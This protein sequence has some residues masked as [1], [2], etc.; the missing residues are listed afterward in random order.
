MCLGSCLFQVN[1]DVDLPDN[2]DPLES[3]P[4]VQ[5][6]IVKKTVEGHDESKQVL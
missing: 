6:C 5:T 1:V 4:A 3:K 2:I